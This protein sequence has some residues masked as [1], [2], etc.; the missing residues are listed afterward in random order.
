LEVSLAEALLEISGSQD[1][2]RICLAGI[3]QRAE[4][5]YANS[6]CG[7]MDQIISI[8]GRKNHA[9]FLD[10]RD[11]SIKY[12]PFNNSSCRLIVFNSMVKH[13]IAGGEYSRRRQS[14]EKA[15]LILN[16]RYSD[17][18]TLRDADRNM[19]NSVK[20][21]LDPV[22][23][24]RASHV[25]AE[26]ERVLRAAEALRINNMF[27]FGRLI[28]MSHDSARDL[29]GISIEQ[30][31]FLVDH[32]RKF[33]G[34]FGARIFG[35]GFGGSIVALAEYDK[36][37]NLV[38][39]INHDYKITYGLDCEISLVGTGEGAEIIGL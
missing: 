38:E 35:G 3:C 13:N 21:R 34:V 19:L 25:I 30:T 14:C 22:T 33:E 20:R 15:A 8:I 39:N 18:K 27:E 37:G 17:V 6:P 10:C 5:I 16:S 12:L 4:N 29:Y 31:D 11:L 2:D 9:I 23:Y 28:N 24:S 7:I 1:I 26:N 32:I 36:V